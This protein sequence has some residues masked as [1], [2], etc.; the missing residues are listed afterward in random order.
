M[1]ITIMLKP[2]EAMAVVVCGEARNEARS[3]F[4]RSACNAVGQAAV[5][6][7]G[8]AGNDID[9]VVMVAFAHRRLRCGREGTAGPSAT[10]GMT[11]FK[12]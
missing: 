11:K 1:N 2:H 12:W 7:S 9:V 3:M 10:L 5:E 8:S 6:D 4:L